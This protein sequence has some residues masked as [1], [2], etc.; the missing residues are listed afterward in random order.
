[1][2]DSVDYATG[3]NTET[4][5]CDCLATLSDARALVSTVLRWA[6]SLYREG[7]HRV[8]L[9]TRL[10]RRWC[11]SGVDID[12][13]I[14]S[15]FHSSDMNKGSDPRNVFRIVAELVRSKNFSVGKYLQWLIATGSLNQSQDTS[16]VCLP[17]P[18]PGSTNRHLVFAMAA[19][20]DN[21]DSTLR[22]H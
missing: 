22:P 14:L 16:S 5:A 9:A 15:Y 6:S 10:L 11:R 3:L 19:A 20:P 8:Y 4:L 2:L 13:A 21:G 7:A 12:G 17:I 1:M 18:V